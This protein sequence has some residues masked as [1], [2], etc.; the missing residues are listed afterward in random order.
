MYC[1]GNF[2][3][4]GKESSLLTQINQRKINKLTTT[5]VTNENLTEDY[6][7]GDI[8]SFDLE[9]YKRALKKYTNNKY[10]QKNSNHFKNK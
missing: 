6:I 7:L 10:G 9:V 8:L 5:T 1:L 4:I 3:N 2:I